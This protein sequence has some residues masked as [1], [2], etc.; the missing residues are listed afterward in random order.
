M[1]KS[2]CKFSTWPGL[3]RLGPHLSSTSSLAIER[4]DSDSV[5]DSHGNAEIIFCKASLLGG[6]CVGP[7]PTVPHH[8]GGVLQGPHFLP[9]ER[10]LMDGVTGH[11]WPPLLIVGPHLHQRLL[12][13]T[14][15]QRVKDGVEGAVNGQDE[16][17][18]PRGNGACRGG[19]RQRRYCT[20]KT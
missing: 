1:F 12:E 10:R 5:A 15:G 18:H 7:A 14:G 2:T 6:E 20:R 16:Y 8:R 17:D 13:G 4:T 3:F 11:R 19:I 9:G